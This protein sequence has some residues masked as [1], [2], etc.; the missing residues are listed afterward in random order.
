MLVTKD[1]LRWRL[2]GVYQT[3]PYDAVGTQLYDVREGQWSQTL[4]Q[5]IGLDPAWLPPVAQPLT[6][7]GGLLPQAAQDTGLPAGVPVVT[8]SGDS[9]VEAFGIGAVQPGDCIIKLGTAANVNL[10]TAL[11]RPSTQTITYPH[12][13]QPHWFSISATNSGAA[14]M[15]WFRDTFCRYEVSQAEQTGASVYELIDQLGAAA[16]PG[17][18]GL[19]FHPYLMG[20]RSPH[21]DPHLRGDFVGIGA[22]HTIHH[23][24][25]AVLEGVAFSIRDCLQVVRTLGEPLRRFY[26][27]GGGARSRLWQEI[28]CNVL[29]QELV[30]PFVADAAFGSA[31]LAGAAAGVFSDTDTVRRAHTVRNQMLEPDQRLHQFYGTYFEIYQAVTQ[32]LAA[33]SQRLAALADCSVSEQAEADK[34]E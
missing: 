12:V 7:A 15:R 24:A 33:H 1:Y 25:R 8:G 4:C 30:R 16:P 17:C 18:Q 28:L 26:L 3:D 27:I 10:V 11:P 21:W 23:F 9:V 32:D 34:M 2:T 14:T 22:Y 6:I 19:L 29:G 20:E 13:A 5:L 31:L